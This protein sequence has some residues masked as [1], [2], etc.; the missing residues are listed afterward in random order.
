VTLSWA[1]A[2]DDV[3]VAGYRVHRGSSAGF[4]PS[5]ANVVGTSTTTSHVDSSVTDEMT[6]YYVVVAVDAAGNVS[7]ASEELRVTTP[8]R[9]QGTTVGA[10]EDALVAQSVPSRNY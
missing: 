6:Y 10:D 4:S 2:T 7:P 9:E 5:E 1:A 8:D 3:G